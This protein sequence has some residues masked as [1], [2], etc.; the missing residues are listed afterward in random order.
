MKILLNLLVLVFFAAPLLYGQER[1]LLVQ[2]KVISVPDN[3]PIANAVVTI[4][5]TFIET[6]TGKN[7]VF[8][9]AVAPGDELVVNAFL[10]YPKTV[11][12]APDEPSMEIQMQYNAEVLEAI[13]VREREGKEEYVEKDFVKRS[14]KEV[15]YSYED[16]QTRFISGIDVDLYT[17]ARKIPMLDVLGSPQEG[18]V[19]YNSRMRGALGGSKVP[20]QVVVDGIPVDQNAL[21]FI[22]PQQITNIT[23]YRSL[24]ATVKY[25]TFGAGGVMSI[26]TSNS[27][28]TSN[29]QKKAG[30]VLVK[31]NNYNE[32]VLPISDNTTI[33]TARFID[34]IRNYPTLPEAQRVYNEQ[35]NLPETRNLAYYLDMANYFSKWGPV[36]GYTVL[37]D[38]FRQANDNPRILRAIAFELEE[39]N[40][41]IQ[42]TFVMERLLDAHPD[43]I[44][45]YRDVARLYA[46]TGRYNL[47]TALYKQMIY[48]TVPNVDFEPIHPIIFNEFRHLIA[49]HK[50]KI[51]FRGIPNEFLSVNFKKDVRIVLE[52]TNPLAEFEVQFVSPNKKYFTWRH[53]AFN[54][55]DLIEDEISRGYAI[56]EFTIE[57]EDFGNWL[58]NVKSIDGDTGAIPTLLKYT[59]YQDYG[60]PTETKKIKVI[61]LANQSEKGTLD[62]FIY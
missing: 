37:A 30:S 28:D 18:Q 58:V 6:E 25:G 16:V 39:K 17:V 32:G 44:Q 61:N 46:A 40:H 11:T 1:D 5:N 7:G 48:N 49:N 51:D 45:A 15:G 41:L 14:K 23:V 36:H 29:S 22:D 54:N 43:N 33:A 10:M 9:L 50:S 59:I 24:A 4:K 19:V 2:G 31:G 56:K 20:I 57:D 52:Y 12:V 3:Q 42:A 34:E 13:T 27:N 38:L 62:T 60:L 26:T 47:A 55:E 8:T 53:A 35:R 21:G